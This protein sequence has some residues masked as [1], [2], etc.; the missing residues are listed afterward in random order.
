MKF[1]QITLNDFS[2]GLNLIS[3]IPGDVV[4]KFYVDCVHATKEKAEELNK[5]Y[6]E[7]EE[8]KI[9]SDLLERKTK[10]RMSVKGSKVSFEEA[11]KAARELLNSSEEYQD[12]MKARKAFIE[13]E[14]ELDL[15]T[16]TVKDL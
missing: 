12:L 7:L 3:G 14:F 15:P 11:Q 1:N 2:G 8:N 9:Y 6:Q 10:E 4:S 16:I 13:T 5:D